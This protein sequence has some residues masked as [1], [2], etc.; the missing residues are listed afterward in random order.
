RVVAST[1]EELVSASSSTN[2]VLP[3]A[4]MDD[5]VP[6]S[7]PELSVLPVASVDRVIPKSAIDR[8]APIASTT[9]I[10]AGAA[11][12]DVALVP[13]IDQPGGG[14]ARGALAPAPRHESSPRPPCRRYARDWPGS[15]RGPDRGQSVGARSF[16]F[17]ASHSPSTR[18][19]SHPG[20]SD[21]RW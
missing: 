21:I 20:G 16:D 18:S 12:Q 7:T 13:A 1:A 10:G 9:D 6:W 19:S 4:A 3:V 2:A 11:D 14:G 5:I 8:L 17:R 15:M